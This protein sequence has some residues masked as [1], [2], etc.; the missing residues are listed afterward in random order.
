MQLE[1][2]SKWYGQVL[3]VSDVN[4][5]LGAGI[6]GLLGPN[7]AGKS[8]IIKLLAGLLRPSR[9]RVRVLGELVADSAAARRRIG[10][11]PEHDGVWEELTGREFVTALAELSGLSR[12]RAAER[13]EEELLLLGLEDA[14]DRRLSGYS[15]GMRQRAKLAQAFVHDPDVLL[16]DE[17]LTGCDPIARVKIVARIK[18]L[19]ARKKTILVSSH[20]LHEIESL[21]TEIVVIYR[22]KVLAE[23]NTY[24]IRELIDEHPHRVR[25][26]CDRPRDLARQLVV[27]DHVSRVE[28]EDGALELETHAPDR[29]Y[30]ALPQAAEDAGVEI[31]SL[32]SPDNNLQA[33][34]E[35]LT[36]TGGRR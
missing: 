19:G 27:C 24:R 4:L 7:G 9:G 28:L 8:T 16:L 33:G 3:G 21:T 13:A 11:C 36:S 22:G 26:E 15:R 6:V 14:L 35:Y 25:V 31:R 5:G 29:L 20:V 17:P 1:G 34:F 2:A 18:D 30:D 10:H 23:G 12:Q 32:T